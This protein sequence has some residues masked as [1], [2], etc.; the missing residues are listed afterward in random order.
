[1]QQHLQQVVELAPSSQFEKYF[2]SLFGCGGNG[3]F[4][5]A[6]ADPGGGIVNII[7]S[8]ISEIIR[9]LRPYK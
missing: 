1:M 4:A 5:A 7:G 9:K 6:A 8:S 2:I 3:A